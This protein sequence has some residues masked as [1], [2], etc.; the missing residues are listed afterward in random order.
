M[1]IQVI[2][3]NAYSEQYS[4]VMNGSGLKNKSH[5]SYYI[6]VEAVTTLQ[7][8]SRRLRQRRRVCQRAHVGVCVCVR[9]GGAV[10]VYGGVRACV[11]V[12]V[13]VCVCV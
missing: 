2:K 6:I 3:N 5:T 4:I 8:V 11:C 9:V 12:C 7:A 10:W 1:Y 13:R